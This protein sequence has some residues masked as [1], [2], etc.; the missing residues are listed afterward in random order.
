MFIYT[1]SIWKFWVEKME[2]LV[3]SMSM[4]VS[5]IV[6]AMDNHNDGI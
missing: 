5:G 3:L 1:P 6:Y 4:S 2:N